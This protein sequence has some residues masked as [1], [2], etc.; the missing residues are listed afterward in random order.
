[1]ADRIACEICGKPVANWEDYVGAEPTEPLCWAEA[2]GGH[3]PQ[4]AIDALRA[5]RADLA[6][7]RALLAA[8]GR[9][10]AEH[11][12]DM[13]AAALQDIRDEARAQHAT[14]TGGE[15]GGALSSLSLP[16]DTAAGAR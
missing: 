5:A 13:A 6:R 7:L 10:V 14:G 11:D 1:M 12:E 16:L 9:A 2:N 15:G 8:Y 3:S 4:H